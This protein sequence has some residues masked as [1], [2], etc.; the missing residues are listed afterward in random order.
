MGEA[1]PTRRNRRRGRE[2]ASNERDRVNHASPALD[3]TSATEA[4]I[5]GRADL[6]GWIGLRTSRNGVDGTSD[7][8]L[9]GPTDR[10]DFLLRSNGL[11]Q[12]QKRTARVPQD[13]SDRFRKASQELLSAAQR[14]A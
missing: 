14:L 1:N 2:R 5:G 3:G 9:S 8:V 10:L 4:R 13:L 12:L 7:D 11:D 6:I